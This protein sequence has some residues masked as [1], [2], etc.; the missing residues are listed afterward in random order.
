M[1]LLASDQGDFFQRFQTVRYKARAEYI[2]FGNALRRQ[3]FKQV[4]RGR[5]HP[6]RSSEPAL[7]GN[8]I[9]FFTQR[10]R[11][12]KQLCRVAAFV[13]I[14]VAVVMV[15]LRN[16]VETQQ[17]LFPASVFR[18]IGLNMLFHRTDIACIVVKAG[19]GAHA[20]L[21][22]LLRQCGEYFVQSRPRT[23]C[24]ILRIKR[25]HQNFSHALRFQLAQY[26]GYGRFAVSHR[27][28]HGYTVQLISQRLGQPLGVECQR[29]AFVKPDF[30]VSVRA[31]F[32]AERQNRAAQYRLP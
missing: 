4:L 20:H 24:R 13:G 5:F 32:R 17:Q 16:T 9:V 14:R 8:D 26:V 23:G 18:P 12:G 30:G 11:L 25:Y 21:V 2:K 29:R 10:Q 27:M 15:F 6:F 3:V 28:A 22:A 31:F 19:Y 1:K 7:K